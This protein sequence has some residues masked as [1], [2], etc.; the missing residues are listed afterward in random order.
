MV[1]KF[2]ALLGNYYNPTNP[3]KLV[4]IFLK[5]MFGA[6][7]R[8]SWFHQEWQKQTKGHAVLTTGKLGIE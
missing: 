7:I 3:N 2:P 4:K 6:W 5:W 1:V 8:D